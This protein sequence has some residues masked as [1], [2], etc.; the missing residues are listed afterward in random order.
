MEKRTFTVTLADGTSISN[1]E[2]N[3][4]NFI[5]KTELTPETFSGKLSKVKIEGPEDCFDDAGLI[6]EHKNMELVQVKKYGDEYWF[7]LRD[8]SQEELK[9]LK[10]RGDIEYIAMMSGIEL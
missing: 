1:L 3:G 4:N 2:L 9:E 6:G 5:S 7:I 8:L 10:N